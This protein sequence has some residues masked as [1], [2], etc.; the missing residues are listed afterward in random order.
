MNHQNQI[1]GLQDALNRR[2]FLSNSVGGLGIAALANLAIGDAVGPAFGDQST[3]S[4]TGGLSD[5]PHMAAKAK[6]VIYLFQSGAPSQ[7]ELFDYKPTL[8]KYR[9][10]DLPDSIRNGQRLTGMS[11]G[12]SKFPV[13]P[14]VF[15]FSKKGNCGADWS[16]LMPFTGELVDELAIIRSMNTEAINHDPAITFFQ[17]GNQLPGRPSI[18]SWLA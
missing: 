14:S 9:G 1:L 12:Q 17:T 11:S 13:A 15:K 2:L 18:G 3:K 16:E 10:E 7:M 8:E 5:L 6:R 4:I